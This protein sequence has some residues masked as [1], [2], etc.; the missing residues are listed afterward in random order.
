MR[1]LLP[2]GPAFEAGRDGLERRLLVGPEG[3]L[4]WPPGGAVALARQLQ[5]AR[6]RD[7]RR[8]GQRLEGS[9]GDADPLDVEAAGLEDAEQLLDGPASAVEADQPA[10]LPGGLDRM[11]GQ[12]APVRGGGAC[13]RID[14]A[15]L[16][17]R[18]RQALRQRACARARGRPADL[19]GEHA[20]RQHRRSRRPARPR[21]Q[22]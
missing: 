11:R 4:H 3:V 18:Q 19:G 9:L 15:R 16:D 17:E 10:R 21:R 13:R 12:Q 8:D 2:L 5:D 6:P 14:L 22:L 20:Q 7:Q 1:V